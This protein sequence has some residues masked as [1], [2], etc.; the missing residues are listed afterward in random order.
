MNEG[1]ERVQGGG[2]GE[3][4]NHSRKMRWPVR[5]S[6]AQLI[7]TSYQSIKSAITLAK[8]RRKG[9]KEVGTC[10]DEDELGFES[11]VVFAF[12]FFLFLGTRACVTCNKNIKPKSQ[13][14]MTTDSSKPPL[15]FCFP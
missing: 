4:D 9:E 1:R 2:Q 11:F 5:P 13:P 8:S 15:A 14:V 3:K 10:R 12:Y 7:I 6:S